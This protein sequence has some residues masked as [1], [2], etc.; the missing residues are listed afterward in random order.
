VL[1]ALGQK[2]IETA[3]AARSDALGKATSLATQ[4]MTAATDVFKTT[5]ASKDAKEARKETADTAATKAKTEKQDAAFKDLKENAASYL[6]VA[7]AKPDA[8]KA[9]EYA[10]SLL[11]ELAGGEL[12]ANLAS[13]LFEAFDK[14]EGTPPARTQGSTAWLKAMGLI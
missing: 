1:Q 14:Q 3:E 5:Q 7:N 12:P 13:K 2:T 8:A 4:A 10:R 6:G 11:K 9:E